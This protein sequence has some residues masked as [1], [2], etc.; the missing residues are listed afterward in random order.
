MPEGVLGGG[1]HDSWGY[2][3]PMGRLTGDLAPSALELSLQV[4]LGSKQVDHL[5]KGRSLTH[6][7]CDSALVGCVSLR[8]AL[9]A[10]LG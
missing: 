1:R 2:R 9:D 4:Q 3:G 8:F 10:P 7:G 5:A 6:L